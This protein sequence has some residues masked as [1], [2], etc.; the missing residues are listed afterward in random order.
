MNKPIKQ[1][2]KQA[3]KQTE[4]VKQAIKQPINQS[5]TPSREGI[6]C[7]ADRQLLTED[8]PGVVFTEH[9]IRG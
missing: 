2:S 9:F 7:V 3:S 8:P 1:S 6:V 5:I 4:Y